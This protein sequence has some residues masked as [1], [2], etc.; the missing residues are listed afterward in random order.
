MSARLV[1]LLGMLAACRSDR[2]SPMYP[3]GT[4]R[5]DGYGDLAQ[6]SAHLLTNESNDRSLFAPR[7]RRRHT[8]DPYGGAM[9]GG[10]SYGDPDA[11]DPRDAPDPS[12]ASPSI[13]VRVSG[14]RGNRYHALAG[15]TGTIEGTVSWRG[16]PPPP[17]TTTCGTF[18]NP[19]RVTANR[20]LAGVLVYIEHVDTGR[21]LPSHG[22][23]V[24]VGGILVKRGCTLAPAV[25]L[26]APLPAGLAIHGDAGDAKLLVTA[27]SGPRA[28]EL[29]PAGRITLQAQAGVTRIESGDGSLSAAWVLATDTPYYAITDDAGHFRLDEL[30]PGSYELAF[31][32]APLPR[33][34]AGKLIYGP[35]VIVHRSIKIDATHPARL[36]VAL[37]P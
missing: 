27:P 5:D 20:A 17:L 1:L 21:E 23:G 11:A 37:E 15:L 35:P 14:A 19:I 28:F 18:A 7:H 13:T 24:T 6:K 29:Q 30:A 26:I 36:D 32:R 3:A 9:Y 2:R 25:Q 8:G 31:W 16:A 22:H 4:D 34:A 33:I 10:A 12:A